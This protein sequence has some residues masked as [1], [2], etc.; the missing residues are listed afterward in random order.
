MSIGTQTRQNKNINLGFPL[1]NMNFQPLE[2]RQISQH[3]HTQMHGRGST[4]TGSLS[5]QPT[6]DCALPAGG[7]QWHQTWGILAPNKTFPQFWV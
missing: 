2:S 3:K 1:T 6:R 4:A 7:G 5:L